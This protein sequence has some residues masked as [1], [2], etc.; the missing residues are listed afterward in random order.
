MSEATTMTEA[1]ALRGLPKGS[2]GLDLKAKQTAYATAT[3]PFHAEGDEVSAHPNL[4][5]DWLKKGFVTNAKPK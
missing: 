1:E 4:I 3:A 5:K 2:K